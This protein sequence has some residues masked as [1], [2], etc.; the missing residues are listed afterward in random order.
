LSIWKFEIFEMSFS[1]LL[2]LCWFSQARQGIKDL[3][4]TPALSYAGVL[5][6]GI[7]SPSPYTTTPPHLHTAKALAPSRMHHQIL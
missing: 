6:G 2:W 1:D 7:P 3:L 4:G 5:G